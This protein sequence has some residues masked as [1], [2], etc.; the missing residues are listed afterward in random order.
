MVPQKPEESL[1]KAI[2]EALGR[3]KNLCKVLQRIT[4]NGG[5]VNPKDLERLEGIWNAVVLLGQRRVSFRD[6]STETV[7]HLVL[8]LVQPRWVLV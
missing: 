6:T 3:Y 8:H 2:Q 7:L 1:V 5:N 4:E